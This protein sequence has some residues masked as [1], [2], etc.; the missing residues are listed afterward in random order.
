MDFNVVAGLGTC[1]FTGYLA[2]FAYSQLTEL[3]KQPTQK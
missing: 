3:R 1:L 2:F